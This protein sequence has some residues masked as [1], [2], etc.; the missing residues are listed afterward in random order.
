MKY[1]YLDNVSQS[2]DM[3]TYF[4]GY[5]HNLSCPEGAF[6]DVKNISTDYFPILSPRKPRTKGMQFVNPQGLLDKEDLIWVD[7]GC[8][9][10]NN[11]MKLNSLDKTTD[12]TITK[13]GAYIVIMPDRVYYNVETDEHGN[14]EASVSKSQQISF[15][16]CAIDGTAITWHDDDYYKSHTPNNGDYKMSTVNGK[17]SLSVYAS[18]TKLW[19]SVPTTYM[20]IQSSGIGAAFEK[21]DGVKITLN[22]SSVSWDWG[23]NY[24]FV[25]DEGEGKVSST[26]VIADKGNDY[27]TVTALLNENK[28]FNIPFT[29]GRNVPDMAFITEC[30][31]RLWGCS[32]DGHEI[33]CCK[34]GDVK[35]WNVF[36]GISTDSWAATIGTDGK[37]TG[38][39][40][41]LGYPIFF[42]EDSLVRVNISS[43]GGHSTKDLRCRGVQSGSE[44]SLCMLNELLYYKSANGICVYDGNFPTEISDALGKVRYSNAVGGSFNNRYY[45]S[46]QDDDGKWH[47]FVYDKKHEL[48]SKEDNTHAKVFCT[49]KD[50][51]FFIGA[52]N[53]LW[54]IDGATAFTEGTEEKAVEW[55]AESGN[56][57]YA[58][59]DKK[60]VARFNV[61]MFLA[62]ESHVS[63]FIQYDEGSWIYLWNMSGHGIKTFTIPVIP[64]RCDHFKIRLLGHGDAKLYSI[65]KSIEEGSDI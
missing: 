20:K 22:L 54:G 14:M 3:V 65:A 44:K 34:L 61:R 42:K 30:Q 38:A 29:V 55:M 33:Y 23:K 59:S 7:D 1:P 8:L 43:T 6:Y 36:Q 11:E 21:E 40:T 27:I 51:L 46:M 24:I 50:S 41:Y 31:N 63:M 37:F 10:I 52:D 45:I 47:M 5:N 19:S 53:F 60:Y 9:Y 25:N 15:T 2:K 4:Q 35:N 57:G 12:K 32:K 39:V 16:L 56:I 13:M 58:V 62:N 28:T 26:F 48:W 17:T 18:A 64:K 49:H